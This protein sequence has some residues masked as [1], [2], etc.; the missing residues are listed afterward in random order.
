[1]KIIYITGVTGSWKTTALVSLCW[2][3]NVFPHQLDVRNMK[4]WAVSVGIDELRWD[5]LQEEVLSFLKFSWV[6]Y[7]YISS[8]LPPTSESI[9]IY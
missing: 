6:R 5:I 9:Y 2:E 7:L 3:E 1:M 4:Q 8:E